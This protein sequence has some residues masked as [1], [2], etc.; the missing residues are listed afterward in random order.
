MV[1]HAAQETERRF[2]RIA[3]GLLWTIIFAAD[4]DLAVDAR[5]EAKLRMRFH[6]V[7]ECK[8]LIFVAQLRPIQQ[9][10]Y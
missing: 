2:A 1:V 10:Q 3:G 7:L 8:V 5:A 6:I 4:D 9:F